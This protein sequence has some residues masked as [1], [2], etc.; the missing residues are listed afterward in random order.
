GDEKGSGAKY[1]FVHVNRGVDFAKKY[2]PTK[3]YDKNSVSSVR[4]MIFC[5]LSHAKISNIKF[6]SEEEKIAAFSLGTADLLSQMAMHDYLKKLPILFD[7]FKEAYK[8]EGIEK[9]K[10]KGHIVFNS[11]DELIKNTPNYY[12]SYV[13]NR[14]KEMGSVY[15]F[16]KFHFGDKKNYYIELIEKNLE[17]IKLL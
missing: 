8:Y 4:D 6:S 1:T 15:Q 17:R 5:T 14:F 13:K 16:I 9:V 2:L 10:Q 7:E 12:E 11:V 3:G